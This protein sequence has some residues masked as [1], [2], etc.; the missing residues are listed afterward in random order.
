LGLLF[1]NLIPSFDLQKRPTK[2]TRR[3]CEIKLYETKETKQN[4]SRGT[5]RHFFISKIHIKRTSVLQ[6]LR[7]YNIPNLNQDDNIKAYDAPEVTPL[8]DAI[9]Q[10]LDTIDH[11][12]EEVSRLRGIGRCGDIFDDSLE[13]TDEISQGKMES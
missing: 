7:P 11:L 3:R 9:E 8:F 12:N 5:R 4:R 2:D 10:L 13:A 1:F 6:R